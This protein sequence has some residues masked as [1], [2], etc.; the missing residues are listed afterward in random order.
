MQ[1]TCCIK[2]SFTVN[3]CNKASNRIVS[4]TE[5]FIVFF[6]K[7]LSHE[8]CRHFPVH[9]RTSTYA[10]FENLLIFAVHWR[11]YPFNIYENQSCL[12]YLS[13]F[14]SLLLWK[15]KVNQPGKCQHLLLLLL[16]LQPRPSHLYQLLSSPP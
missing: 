6:W 5:G 4:K 2:C 11:I 8:V 16:L 3:Y 15:K 10:N 1:F 13:L 9:T 12:C 7:T 14:F